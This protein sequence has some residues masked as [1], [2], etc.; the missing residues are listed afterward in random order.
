MASAPG[1]VSSQHPQETS[2]GV[3]SDTRRSPPRIELDRD[4]EWRAADAELKRYGP[5]DQSSSKMIAKGEVAGQLRPHGA[6]QQEA[7]F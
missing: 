4:A 1:L 7:W 5:A 3:C 6:L 2:W